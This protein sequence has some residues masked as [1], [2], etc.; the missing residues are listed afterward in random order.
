MDG[1]SLDIKQDLISKLKQLIPTAFTEGDKL[2]TEKL[3]QV[4]GDEI[5]ADNERYFLNWAGKSEVFNV[6]QTPTTATLAPDIDESI[7]FDTTE[8]IFIE[9][10][11]LEVLKVLQKSYYGKIK[12]IY[13]D[14]P[15]NTGKDSFIYPDK[16]E[17]NKNEYLK[18][19]EEKDEEGFMM[20]E[21]FFRKNGKENGHYHSNWL[22]MMYP[23]LYLA[24]NLLKE[25][26]VIFISIDDNEVHN[27]RIIL[28]EIYGE[29]NFLAELVWNLKSGSQA[30][31]FTRSHEYVLCYCKDKEKLKYF[32]DLNG[33]EIKHG[34][35]KKISKDNPLSEIEFPAGMEF[36]GKDKIFSGVL[37]GSEQQ[38]IK[39]KEMIFKKG[40]LTKPVIL[41]AGWAMRDQVL[42]WLRGEETYDTKG[43]L[44]KKF[45]FNS[46]GILWYEKER[47]TIHPKT[48]LPEWIGGTKRGSDEIIRLFGTKVFDFPKP[49]TLIR[50]LIEFSIKKDEI[51]LDFFAGSGPTS[52]AALELNKEDNGKR[53]FILVQLPE[54][55]SNDSEAFKVGYKTIADVS[56]ERIRR[57][58]HSI[59]KE[60]ED[61][62]TLFEG[63]LLDLGFKV[64]KLKNSN[65]KIWRSD[66]IEK[67]D[68]LKKQL[69]VFKNPLKK[70]AKELNII[71]ELLLKLG[72]DLNTKIEKE[73]DEFTFYRV[74]NNKLLIFTEGKGDIKN[75]IKQNSEKYNPEKVIALDELFEGND[76][77]KTNVMLQ[78]KDEGIQFSSI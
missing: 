25:D 1:N 5:N 29:E 31:H 67:G 72:F 60:R 47:G 37:G 20:K 62:P 27:L 65:F 21:G 76:E 7:N 56:K 61:N 69:E 24:R 48:V 75:S 77:A 17:E 35:L 66:T 64:L 3:K 68:D 10:E 8:N 11:N 36:E 38:F 53:K 34:A 2:D 46:S 12:M 4:L 57:V 40:K 78:L 63:K 41:E 26:G 49:S 22:S 51:V 73:I 16:F 6:L 70:E 58:I 9:G 19:I 33:G 42:S 43:Q 32:E 71:F 74:D 45:Y 59:E 55:S 50:Y 44:V 30:G 13:I 23:R 15:Y 39:S 18:R 14:P 54:P 28:N 52:Q